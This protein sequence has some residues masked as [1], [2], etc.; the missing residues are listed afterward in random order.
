[1][2]TY[3]PVSLGIIWD[4]LISIADETLSTLVRTSFSTNV[5]E[6][7]DLSCMLFDTRMRSIAQGTYSVPSFTGTAPAT[8]RQ[9]LA[10]HPPET[11]VEGDVLA[12]N[13]PWIGTGHLYDIN[14]LRPI[15]H[16]G[17]LVGYSLSI[18]HLP[19]IGGLGFSATARQVYE[20]GLRLPVVK[21]V[22]GGRPNPL[23][24]DIIAT[25]VR[26][27]EQTIG[28]IHANIACNEVAGRLLGEFLNE[29][30][31]DE[32]DSVADAI[33]ESSERGLRAAIAKMA[34]GTYRHAIDIEGGADSLRLAVAMTVAGDSIH[35]DFSGTS[36]AIDMG[37]NVPLAYAKAFAV[38]A[39]KCVTT[40]ATPNNY[41]CV[42][43]IT[44][45][46][47]DNCIL[48]A[49][50][51]YPT[52]GRHVIGHFV[53]PLMMGAL[54]QVVP[55]A[56]Q[57]DSGMLSLVNIQGRRRDGRGVS[58]IY[59]SSGGFGALKGIDGA[60]TMPNPSNMTG[61]PVEVWE[62]I[63]GVTVRRK[64]LLPD[65]GGAGEFRGG[66]GQ[67]IEL[68]ND[69]GNDLTVS[70]LSG[71]TQ[72][73]ALGMAGGRPGSLRAVGVN[74]TAVHPKGRYILK[75]GDVL[76]LVEP[77]GG[78][79]GDPARRDPRRIAADL[80][81]GHVTPDG[82]RRDYGVDPDAVAGLAAPA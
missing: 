30:G 79:F 6:S 77:G 44:A 24:F 68:V 63:T 52:G 67:E 1:M 41:G 53:N 73:P 12:T 23:L 27:P 55:E 37:I 7:Y 78:G 60:P 15:F 59:F 49:L 26:V 76:T 50:P 46:A 34:D 2:S 57:A 81:D 47:P 65:S 5:R 72:F 39:V 42:V 51:P 18:T 19:D 33:I 20:E 70:C 16:R 62:D 21:L 40:P 43:P 4:R 48:N 58:S 36:H 35:A 32:I 69:T 56:V 22:E 64:A 31:L 17:R 80:R 71:R 10:V 38:Y 25:N 28:D 61:T 14:V 29:A 82:A 75:P 45:S 8:V 54:A 13:D 74:G 11:L 9:M 3:D 66:L